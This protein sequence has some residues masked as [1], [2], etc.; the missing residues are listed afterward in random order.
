MAGKIRSKSRPEWAVVAWEEL[1]HQAKSGRKLTYTD[2]GSLL[3]YNS[4][5][6]IG[7]ILDF[8]FHYCKL[9]RLPPLTVIVVNKSTGVP[10]DGMGEYSPGDFDA[11]F[12]YDWQSHP[13]PSPAEFKEAALQ[14][15]G[16]SL[17]GDD[18]N[19]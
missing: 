19:S 10:G 5:L 17:D 3:G 8:I 13:V 7:P 1:V 12:R 2:L 11:V 18:D 16:Q 9:R 4:P 14:S 15:T 6:G